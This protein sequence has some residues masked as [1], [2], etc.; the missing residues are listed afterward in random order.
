MVIA[1][2]T[3]SA[4]SE[5]STHVQNAESDKVVTTGPYAYVPVSSD[6]LFMCRIVGCQDNNNGITTSAL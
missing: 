3:M 5:M 4:V 2:H 6:A 1:A